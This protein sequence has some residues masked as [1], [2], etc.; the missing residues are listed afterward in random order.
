MSTLA[1]MAINFHFTH[2]PSLDLLCLS[3]FIPSFL[4]PINLSLSNK[5][6]QQKALVKVHLYKEAY[7]FRN[8]PDIYHPNFSMKPF[9]WN[10]N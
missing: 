8:N 5:A 10:G 4:L 6:F 9:L 3:L 1:I 7:S 2:Q